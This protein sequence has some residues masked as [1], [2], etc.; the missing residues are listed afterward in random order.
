MHLTWRTLIVYLFVEEYLSLGIV[1]SSQVISLH[2]DGRLYKG[3]N[4]PTTRQNANQTEFHF[5][6]F[7]RTFHIS[8]QKNKLLISPNFKVVHQTQSG[9][10]RE[11][12]QVRDCYYQGHLVGDKNSFVVF[13]TCGGV[14]GF[15]K[16]ETGDI[17][18]VESSSS[19]SNS[20]VVIRK[21]DVTT[22]LLTTRRICDVNKTNIRNS[23]VRIN[24]LRTRTQSNIYSTGKSM[25][26]IELVLVMDSREFKKYT[27]HCTTRAFALMNYVDKVYRG[28]DTRVAFTQLVIWKDKDPI[29]VSSSGT[30][31][32]SE[33]QKYVQQTLF[34]SMKI[35]ADSAVLL[36]GVDFAGSLAGVAGLGTM[37]SRS[38]GAVVGDQG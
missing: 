8:L 22:N 24:P 18:V 30:D 38:S 7:N 15:I 11:N 3:E 9:F 32:L 16:T 1:N 35:K 25:K 14:E 23:T 4:S 28:L 10:L 2:Q 5:S 27:T 33:F 31:T 13:R 36:T 37:C 20:K 29:K 17:F 6:A 12:V 21:K 19:S 26:Y 34:G